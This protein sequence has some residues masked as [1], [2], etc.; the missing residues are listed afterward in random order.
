VN[1]HDLIV[2]D[3]L[4][5]SSLASQLPLSHLHEKP[6]EQTPNNA[7]E[8]IDGGFYI[9]LALQFNYLLVNLISLI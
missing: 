4:I 8:I 1:V 9:F 2:E 7:L 6:R 3:V 5:H